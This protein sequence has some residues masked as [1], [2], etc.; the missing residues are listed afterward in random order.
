MYHR[1]PLVIMVNF[2]RRGVD[3]RQV[4][5]FS[6]LVKNLDT[7]DTEDRGRSPWDRILVVSF[8]SAVALLVLL[9][10]VFSVAYGSRRITTNATSLHKA[11]EILRTST[12]VRAQLGLAVY[13]AAVDREV[14]TNS[15]SAIAFS[16]DEAEDALVGMRYGFFGDPL[17]GT[18]GLA[19][20]IPEATD[21]LDSEFGAFISVSESII[22]LLQDNDSQNGARTGQLG[23]RQRIPRHERSTGRV[24]Q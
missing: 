6:R 21:V 22:A 2:D 8:L 12:V 1:W 7:S 9:G 10:V 23:V 24:A 14:G 16:I 15:T 20:D 19:E 3:K 18:S 5:R 17:T 4:S 13:L 11:D